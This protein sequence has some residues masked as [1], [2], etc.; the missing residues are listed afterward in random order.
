[1]DYGCS[2]DCKSAAFG[3]DWFDSSMVHMEEE[4]EDPFE[5]EKPV[6]RIHQGNQ[7]ECES[8]QS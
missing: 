8:C 6:I 2:A 7:E 5:S 4:I 1:M 3:L